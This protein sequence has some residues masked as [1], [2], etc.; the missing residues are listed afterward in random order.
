MDTRF[1][2]KD[3]M[4]VV[5]VVLIGFVL[6]VAD[7][8]HHRLN[9]NMFYKFI[10]S[11]LITFQCSAVDLSG[12]Q[13]I[14]LDRF[15][16][17]LI[18]KSEGGYV[19]YGKKPLCINGFHF[20]D[21]FAS[22]SE[23]HQASVD[24]RE[25]ALAWKALNFGQSDIIVHVYNNHDSLATQWVHILV[26]NKPLFLK[27]V[28]DNLLLFKYVLGPEVTAEEL[29][30]QLTNPKNTFHS[31]LK[32]DKVL[33]GII[34]GFGAENSIYASRLENLEDMLFSAE[35]PPLRS[36][37][38]EHSARKEMFHI[39]LMKNTS[40]IDSRE[41]EP[42]F[43]FSTIAEEIKGLYGKLEVSSWKLDNQ[44][45]RFVFG[46][47]KHCPQNDQL[48]K[49]L[50]ECQ[51]EIKTLL[52]TNNYLEKVL[53]MIVPHEN[54]NL[55]TNL[56]KLI[57]LDVSEKKRLPFVVAAS[58]WNDIRDEDQNFQQAYLL[59]CQDR[60]SGKKMRDE[61]YNFLCNLKLHAYSKIQKKLNET[62]RFLEK[63]DS[64]GNCQCLEPRQLYCRTL[65]KGSGK[66]LESQESI[67]CGYLFKSS[68]GQ[69]L[70]DAFGSAPTEVCLSKAIPG[71]VK[72]VQ[73]MLI[74]EVREMYIH[75]NLGYGLC[76]TGEKGGYLYCKVQL[77]G[78]DNSKN[79]LGTDPISEIKIPV[80]TETE[81]AIEATKF[82][83]RTGYRAWEHYRKCPHYCL[84]QVL[85]EFEKIDKSREDLESE[86]TD[87]TSQNLINRLHWNLNQYQ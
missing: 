58:I 22:E 61:D 47:L 62:D 17:Q 82:G 4:G 83:Y 87:E 31:V 46:I 80:V 24:L 64:D 33:I 71:F 11:L 29:L 44:N 68:E 45:P 38:T 5:G 42:S 55:E 2:T 10:L 86:I 34:L 59:G 63:L 49:G 84:K 39:A 85:Q 54:F 81:I 6:F 50:E 67:S 1:T 36:R 3:I 8:I 25:G 43:G 19:L 32:A 21:E 18:E 51:E 66:M 57:S 7:V 73:G 53:R 27:T 26:I 56:P 65:E 16:R 20:I 40:R 14:I 13:T 37:L 9:M 79:L 23:S 15:F 28:N 76:T 72:G 12:E 60:D 41:F 35:T 52:A 70:C 78:I 69:I 75:P 30:K 48:V 74:G 77:L